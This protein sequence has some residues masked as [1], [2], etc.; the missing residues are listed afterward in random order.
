MHASV[1]L[2]E[3][4]TVRYIIDAQ[5]SRLTVKVFATGLLSSFGHS[6]TIAVRDLTGEISFTLANQSIGDARLKIRVRAE[7]LEVTDSVSDSDREEMH[8]RMYS[9]VLDTDQFPEITYECSRVTASGDGERYWASLSGYLTLRGAT[10]PL[11]ISARVVREPGMVKATGDFS[12]KQSQ[13]G[14]A[15]VSA[16]AGTIRIK[17]ELQCTFEIV[18]R[19]AEHTAE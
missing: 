15:T 12:L 16:A 5:A 14:I 18:A 10:K 7:S 1:P 3:E 13:Y 8:R 17:D 19:E 4:A 6:P 2:P 11:P 9:E